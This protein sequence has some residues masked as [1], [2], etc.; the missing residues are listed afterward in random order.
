MKVQSTGLGKTV[1]EAELT[2]IGGAEF[3]GDR[4]ILMTM[5]SFKPLHWTI[6]VHIEPADVRRTILMGLKP[7]LVWKGIMALFFGRFTLLP[8][9]DKSLP[10]QDAPVV[11]RP[12]PVKDAIQAAEPA[13][14]SAPISGR[15]GLSG[16]LAHPEEKAS[17]PVANAKEPSAGPGEV[18]VPSLKKKVRLPGVLAHPEEEDDTPASE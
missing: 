17:P 5:E 13:V 1:M 12:T 4:V 18:S 11:S 10:M 7:S 2:G 15:T 8:R 3:E 6:K 9:K 14:K 16:V